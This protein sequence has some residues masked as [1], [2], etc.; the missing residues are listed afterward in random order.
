M[1]ARRGKVMKTDGL[2][3]PLGHKTDIQTSFK[4]LG[5]PQ[6]HWN[7]DEEASKYH[8]RV[9][10]VLKSQFNGKNKIKVIN[11]YALSVIRYPA[12]TVNWTKEEMEAADIKT[13]NLLTIHGGFHPKSNVQRL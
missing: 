4:Y 7:H 3:L 5:I 8:Q 11:T 1:I 2:E 10:Q 13:R 12:G 6:L 9:R